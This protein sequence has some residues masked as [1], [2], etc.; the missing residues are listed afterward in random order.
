MCPKYYNEDESVFA[1]KNIYEMSGVEF[2]RPHDLSFV[3][4]GPRNYNPDKR[5]KEEVCLSLTFHPKIDAS[6]IEVTVSKGI[7]HLSGFVSNREMKKEVDKCLDRILGVIDV[8][9]QL[10]LLK[11]GYSFDFDEYELY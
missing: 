9:N 10:Q 8:D 4:K 6:E 2:E 7:V 3:G 5:L 11:N 1:E